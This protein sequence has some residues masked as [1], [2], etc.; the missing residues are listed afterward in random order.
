M[1]K[2]SNIFT[3]KI[4]N[5]FSSNALR[6]TANI[7]AQIKLEITGALLFGHYLKD[8]ISTGNPTLIKNLAK[9]CE[10]CSR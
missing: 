4:R 5:K 10:R 7:Y 2:F 8:G 3:N 1:Q 9:A 6:K